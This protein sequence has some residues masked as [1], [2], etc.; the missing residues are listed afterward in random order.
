[1][2][3]QVTYG[4]AADDE[5]YFYPESDGKPMSD[6]TLQYRWIVLIKENLE[7]LFSAI[8][9][10]FIAGD[11]LWY[12]VQRAPGCAPDIMVVFGRPCM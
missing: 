12:P 6:N 1:M 9:D 3:R 10:I 11:L 4:L 8:K 5:D 2:V 7:I